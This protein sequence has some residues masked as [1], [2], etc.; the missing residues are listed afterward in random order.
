ML[1]KISVSL[2]AL[3][4]AGLAGSAMAACPANHQLTGSSY[5][6]DVNI[7]VAPTVSMWANNDSIALVLD[8]SDPGANDLAIA[9]SSL[10][11]I[12]NVDANVKATVTGALPA[13]IVP[14]GG[15]NFFIFHDTTEADARTYVAANAYTAD[16]LANPNPPA[17]WTNA[18]IGTTKT[19]LGSTGVNTSIA[20]KPILYA[21][22]APGE[23][24]LPNSYN[25][26]VTYTIASNS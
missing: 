14:G 22:D 17:V 20:N 4:V 13:P 12:N 16:P 8:G 7:Q 5:C 3:S 23:I 26:V 2:L 18:T 24:P 25:L 15:I 10:S 21:A 19:I 1:R 9:P 6:V 11:V